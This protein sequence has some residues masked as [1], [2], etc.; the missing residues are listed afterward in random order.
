MITKEQ[1]TTI[2]NMNGY[3]LLDWYN[4]YYRKV[5]K[6]LIPPAEVTDVFEA[7]RHEIMTRMGLERS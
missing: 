5:I 7:L 1:A 4:N 2:H 3:D 6:D